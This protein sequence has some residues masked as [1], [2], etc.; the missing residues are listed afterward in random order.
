MKTT[1]ELNRGTRA[2]TWEVDDMPYI[3][4]GAL[5]HDITYGG[6]Y[7]VVVNSIL[8]IDRDGVAEVIQRLVCGQ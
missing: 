3:P 7:R 8:L 2:R 4:E 1:V 6:A 5:I